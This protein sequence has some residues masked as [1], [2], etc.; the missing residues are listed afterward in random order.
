MPFGCRSAD[1]QHLC[2]FLEQIVGT[3]GDYFPPWANRLQLRWLFRLIKEPR[4]LWKRYFLLYPKFLVL[5]LADRAR[6]R[7]KGRLA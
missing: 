1:T 6:L 5:F 7:G 3:D 2:G 4:R